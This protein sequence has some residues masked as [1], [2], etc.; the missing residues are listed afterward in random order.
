MIWSEI[1][2]FGA[3]E[4][5]LAFG[6]TYP[7]RNDTLTD[8]A[9]MAESAQNRIEVEPYNFHNDSEPVWASRY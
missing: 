5:H 1:Y 9:S 6:C 4:E 2:G 8:K 3:G 7:W